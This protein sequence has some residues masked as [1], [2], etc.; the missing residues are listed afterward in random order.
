MRKVQ[1]AVS[2]LLKM[3]KIPPAEQTLGTGGDKICISHFLSKNHHFREKRRQPLFC[4]TLFRVREL[5]FLA[6]AIFAFWLKYL[7]LVKCMISIEDH[8]FH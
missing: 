7:F 2:R 4:A 8:S 6:F 5:A 3:I 1:K